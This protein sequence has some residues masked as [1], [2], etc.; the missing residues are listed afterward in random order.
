M[1]RP[2]KIDFDPAKDRIN[3]QKHGIS[4]AQAGFANW[5]AVLTR[6]DLRGEYGQ[7]RWISLVPIGYIL[8]CCIHVNLKNETLI[9]S[10]RCAR[11]RE[12]DHYVKRINTPNRL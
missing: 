2:A 8:Y 5:D 4:L 11:Q 10:L 3:Q 9:I 6:R 1:N 7:H 12:F